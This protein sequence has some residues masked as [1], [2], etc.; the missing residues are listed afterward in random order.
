MIA[1][2]RASSTSA[3]D[4]AAAS[5]AALCPDGGAGVQLEQREHDLPPAAVAVAVVAELQI[6]LVESVAADASVDQ[7]FDE[8]VFGVV[9]PL[10]RPRPV[11]GHGFSA[12]RTGSGSAAWPRNDW[13]SHAVVEQPE[14]LEQRGD[15][16]SDTGR[17]SKVT[18]PD[19]SSAAQW[20]PLRCRR[21]SRP[22]HRARAR[23]R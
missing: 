6:Q 21:P 5:F 19:S 18:A 15:S 13:H 12:E 11:V 16:G 23:R 4:R 14:I 1:S 2:S 20:S 22:G 9:G 17:R 10:R 7:F 3:A 8:R